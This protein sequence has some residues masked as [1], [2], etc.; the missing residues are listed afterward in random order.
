MDEV[1]SDNVAALAAVGAI[2]LERVAQDGMRVCA[3]AGA[4]SFR[5]QARLEE[6]QAEARELVEKQRPGMLYRSEVRVSTAAKTSPARRRTA[7]DP[8][9]DARGLEDYTAV[10]KETL[11]RL[12]GGEKRKR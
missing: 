1:L 8:G 5:R 9:E 7:W 11:A 6:H 4:A 2:T 12:D 10:L 3:D